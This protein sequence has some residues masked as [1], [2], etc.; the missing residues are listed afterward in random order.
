M[1]KI[2]VK[3]FSIFHWIEKWVLIW[4]FFGLIIVSAVEERVDGGQEEAGG[5]DHVHLERLSRVL[6]P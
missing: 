2:V 3:L 6:R 5:E 4:L 1:S